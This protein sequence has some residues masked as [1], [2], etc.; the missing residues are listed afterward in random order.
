MGRNISPSDISQITDYLFISSWPEGEH[1]EEIFGK[2]SLDP[3]HAL[4]A[5]F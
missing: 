1:Y 5:S 4:A 3:F 2:Y